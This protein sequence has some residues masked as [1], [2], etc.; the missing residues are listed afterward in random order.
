M[1]EAQKQQKEKGTLLQLVLFI[2]LSTIAAG[3]QWVIA[4]FGEDLLL[5]VNSDLA[6]VILIDTA[7]QQTI[8]AFIGFLVSNIV[9][10]LLSYF[11][12]RKTTF[13]ARKYLAF[14]LTMFIIL[15]VILIV[16]ETLIAIPLTNLFYGNVHYAADG[17]THTVGNAFGQFLEDKTGDGWGWCKIIAI[18]TY[19]LIDLIIVFIM[20]KLVIMN[21]HIFDS[22]EEK[23]KYKAEKAAAKEAKKN[24]KKAPVEEEPVEE[25][26]KEENEVEEVA[27]EPVA[28][29]VEE[30]KEE[31]IEEPAEEE[32]EEEKVEEPAEEEVEEEKVEEPV[33]EEAKAEEPVK[34]EVVVEET[35]E[36]EPVAAPVEEEKVEEPVKEEAPAKKAA[37]KKAPAKKAKEEPK[38]EESTKEEV[39]AEE[40]KKAPAKKTAKKTNAGKVEFDLRVDGYHFEVSAMNGQLMFESQGFASLD[41]AKTGFETFKAALEDESTPATVYEDKRGLWRFV[42]N[43]RYV[44]EGYKTRAQAEAAIDSVKR[45]AL[46][47][48]VEDFVEDPEEKKAFNDAKK[49]LN[50]GAGVDW[51]TALKA[52]AKTFGKFEINGH[53]GRGYFFTLYANNGQILYCSRYYAS[54]DSCEDAITTFK[55][56]C[57]L[58]NF[59]IDKDKFGNW[60][61]VLKGTGAGIVYV[62]ES[63]STKDAAIS[64]SES[65][66]K[67]A[68]TAK[69]VVVEDED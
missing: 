22:K 29:P 44:G 50:K 53:E 32:V 7:F 14:S 56:A 48:K 47:G 39:K 40:P 5:K 68:M 2:A 67:F 3:V 25:V 31:K 19:S 51:N 52:P 46:F 64:S 12:N 59:F 54:Q 45:D 57:Y 42:I 4:Y 28:A 30:V 6:K 43:K 37:A 15:S 34:E 38:A 69:I 49:K 41:T 21:D 58:D 13:G 63:Y 35:K 65:V 1:A 55:K 23:A 27:E 36:E 33:Q 18:V 9:A 26:A 61:F 66:K 10:K 60:R 62:G 16:V 24:G 20:N 11:L 17:V 8:A